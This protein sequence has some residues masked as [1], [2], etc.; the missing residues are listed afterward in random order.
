MDIYPEDFQPAYR[1]RLQLIRSVLNGTLITGSIYS[2]PGAILGAAVGAGL[3]TLWGVVFDRTFAFE[4]LIG[5]GLGA[6]PGYTCG[7]LM[8][9]NA[10]RKK[11]ARKIKGDEILLMRKEETDPLRVE[12]LDLI[13]QL[14][15]MPTFQDK[16]SE[17]SI[18]SAVRDLGS[19]IEKLPGQPAGELLLDAGAFQA[20]ASRLTEEA[21]QERDP[22]VA[23]SL[24]RQSVAQNQRS[25][26]ISRNF[27]LARR[28]QVLRQEMSEHIRAL[29]T[30]LSAANLGDGGE[31]YDLAALTENIERVSVEARS[32]TEAKKELAFALETGQSNTDNFIRVNQ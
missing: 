13:T 5:G 22:V 14:I 29:K 32:L 21:N 31:N 11:C 1:P 2:F 8:D 16:S 3:I 26:V 24:L 7:F 12:Y 18:R 6:V 15:A 17:E 25:E 28:S 9:R 27:A 23:A 4:S 19:S 20:E 30:M 10:S